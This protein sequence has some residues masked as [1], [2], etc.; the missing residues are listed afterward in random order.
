MPFNPK[1]LL[2]SLLLAICLAANPSSATVSQPEAL[3]N[4]G[5][6]RVS[7]D[8]EVGEGLKLLREDALKAR[9]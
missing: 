1:N 8:I 3:K 5:P 9:A 4:S 6:V 2:V 7:V